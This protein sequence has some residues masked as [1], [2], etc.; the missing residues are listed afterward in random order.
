MQI[1]RIAS[2][3]TPPD[4]SLVVAGSTGCRSLRY[5]A[6]YCGRVEIPYNRHGALPGSGAICRVAIF[7][8]LDWQMSANYLS[9]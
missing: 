9:A 4:S 6:T 3:G 8:G 7:W 1:H 5:A 2:T